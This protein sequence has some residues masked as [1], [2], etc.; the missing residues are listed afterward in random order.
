M[1]LMIIYCSFFLCDF[2]NPVTLVNSA[3][4]GH[5]DIVEY[6]LHRSNANPLIKNSFGE[7]AYD[8]A[9]IS[10]EFYICELLEKAERDW[11]KGKKASSQRKS[12]NI[13]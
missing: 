8:V 13:L 10:Q 9:A 4:K 1:K 11:W 3:S 7:T 6:L 12:M 2:C 5:V